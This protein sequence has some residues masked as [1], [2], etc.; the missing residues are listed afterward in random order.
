[1]SSTQ[2]DRLSILGQLELRM[3]EAVALIED[4]IRTGDPKSIGRGA[5]ISA[6]ANQQVLFNPYLESTL[7][8]AAPMGA[9]GVN[10]APQPA[11]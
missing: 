10:F 3:V 4:G 7:E 8:L 2:I 9:V 6:L 11:L 1:M 5:T